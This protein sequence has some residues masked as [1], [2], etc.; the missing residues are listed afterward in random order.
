MSAMAGVAQASGS[1]QGHK[2]MD[3]ERTKE[4]HELAAATE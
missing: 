1:L 2:T 3:A 4:E